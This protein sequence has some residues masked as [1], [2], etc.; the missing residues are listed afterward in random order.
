MRKSSEKWRVRD[1][2]GVVAFGASALAAGLLA[3]DHDGFAVLACVVG[4]GAIAVMDV[5]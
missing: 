2:A 1:I 3:V 5:A 4:F